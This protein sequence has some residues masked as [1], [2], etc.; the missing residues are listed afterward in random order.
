MPSPVA[1]LGKIIYQRLAT[2]YTPSGLFSYTPDDPHGANF[3]ERRHGEVQRISL[4]H[5]P[6]NEGSRG[7]S[8]QDSSLIHRCNYHELTTNSSSAVRR[9]NRCCKDMKCLLKWSGNRTRHQ[10]R[11][12]RRPSATLPLLMCNARKGKRFMSE[13]FGFIVQKPTFRS[14]YDD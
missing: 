11:R 3:R 12:L 10:W 6:V 7:A 2:V 4:P 5:T 14:C 9:E 8:P 13:V 1:K